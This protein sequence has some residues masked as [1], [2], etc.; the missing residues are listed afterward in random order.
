MVRGLIVPLQD[1]GPEAK[2]LALADRQVGLIQAAC[3]GILSE[4]QTAKALRLWAARRAG[5]APMPARFARLC[6]D[7]IPIGEDQA[8]QLC[9]RLAR[10]HAGLDP[11]GD[12]SAHK[13]FAAYL[14]RLLNSVWRLRASLP[15][16]TNTLAPA[17]QRMLLDWADA[18]TPRLEV[19]PLGVR[20][21]QE[22]LGCVQVWLES[23]LGSG[24]T[25]GILERAK[26][27]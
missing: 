4:Q 14:G 10:L 23:H 13:A 7:W 26:S 20:E 17:A 18:D 6:R 27:G 16:H 5:G 12:A 2:A 8:R 11:D 3:T 22:T 24:V 25:K 15:R 1:V 9:R 21:R 19:P